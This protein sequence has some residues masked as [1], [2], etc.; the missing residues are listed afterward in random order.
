[1]KYNSEAGKIER[2]LL[3]K[4]GN[5]LFP[6]LEQSVLP[7]AIEQARQQDQMALQKFIEDFQALVKKA[8]DLEPNTPSEKVLEL[9]EE[10]DRCFQVSYTVPGDLEE[11]RK[12]IQTLVKSI[13]Q[14]V[15]K[16]IGNDDYARQK[17]QDEEIARDMHF[18]LQQ[19]P[20]IADLTDPDSQ[21]QESELIPSLLSETTESLQ[22]VMQIFDEQQTTAIFYEAKTFLDTTDPNK[23]IPLAWDCFAIIKEIFLAAE[24]TN[25]PAQ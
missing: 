24:T 3:R 11:I 25:I 21:I 8:V 17:L 4:Q 14:A 16:G 2:H 15:W 10:L 13:M 22:Q 20:L 1:M 6:M 7:E 23:E 12:A 5:L 9:K 19:N 18:Q